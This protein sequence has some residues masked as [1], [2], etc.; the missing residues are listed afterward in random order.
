MTTHHLRAF[1]EVDRPIDEVFAFFAKPENLGRVT[2]PSMGFELRSKDFAMRE[3]LEVAYRVR[4]ILGIPTPWRSRIVD[5][6][7]PHGFG[8]VQ[9][10]GPYHRWEHH[11]AFI[12]EGS[13]T[14][15]IDE[16]T[17]ELPLGR[18]GDLA[19][20]VVVRR[21][22]E[23]VFRYRAHAIQAIFATAEPNPNPMSVAIAGGSGFVGGGIAAEL[24]RRGNRVIVL[25]R[26]DR[27]SI[28]P[29]PEAVELRRVDVT[30][31]E[32][33]PALEGVDALVI[34]LAFKNS[35]IEAPRRHQTFMEVDAAGTERL[36]AAAGAAGIRHLV[37]LS[38]AGAAP[39]AK[40]HWFRAKWRAEEAIRGSGI[41]WTI[42]R[43]TWIFGPRDV[44]LNR[45]VGFARQLQM[46]PMANLGRQPMAPVFV[47]DI[48]RL[49]ADSLTDPAAAGAVL[50]VGGPAT[51]TMREVIDHALRVAELRRPILPGPTPLIK[52]G[53]LP[54]TLLPK[55]PL[56]P[57]AVDFINQPAVVD[58]TSL[59]ERMPRR[60]TPLDEGLAAYLSPAS[61]PGRVEIDGERP[62]RARAKER[63]A[64]SRTR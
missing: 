44:S 15:V 53:A 28:G 56:T 30:A 12:A 27:G 40:R 31:D 9:V 25:G 29:L 61:T 23:E 5:Y 42:I 39:D 16:V 33:G 13:A 18:L 45:F 10:R 57:D 24:H 7:P 58:T 14:H 46:V 38:G 11:H 54:L 4:P 26:G 6:D 59:E 1:L 52:L 48:A 50:E 20:G 55:P 17:Y 63:A 32:L 41:G 43:P 34:A 21:Q 2:P 51:F 47:D 36:A 49:A 62:G 60:L 19:H 22:L 37:Y 8:D 3:G 35:P 64:V